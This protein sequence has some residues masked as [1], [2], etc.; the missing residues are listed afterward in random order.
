MR[1]SRESVHLSSDRFYRYPCAAPTLMNASPLSLSVLVG[2][3]G[4]VTWYPLHTSNYAEPMSLSVLVGGV[5][6]D[7]W[8]PSRTPDFAASVFLGGE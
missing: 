1:R 2:G 6:V 7:T 3:V 4:F 5:V 8:S